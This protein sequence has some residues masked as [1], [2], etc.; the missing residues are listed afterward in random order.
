MV[1]VN[2]SKYVTIVVVAGAPGRQRVEVVNTMQ[3]AAGRVLGLM[4]DGVLAVHR[5]LGPGE[6]MEVKNET[7]PVS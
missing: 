1:V 4:A 7:C 2:L 3:E 5:A 6:S